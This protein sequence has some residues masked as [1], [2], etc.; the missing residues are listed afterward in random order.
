MKKIIFALMMVLFITGFY[1]PSGAE[2]ESKPAPVIIKIAT[3]M[4]KR[5]YVGSILDE[6][7]HEVRKK[8]NNEVGFKFYYD[9][10]M[11]DEPDVLR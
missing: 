5:S 3:I 2:E 8:T 11:G 9:G 10:R 6:F 4:P 1:A 7:N